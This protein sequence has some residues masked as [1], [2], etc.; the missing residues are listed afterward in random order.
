MSQIN[1]NQEPNQYDASETKS[2]GDVTNIYVEGNYNKKING[3]YIHGNSTITQ[4]SN[5]KS[6][7]IEFFNEHKSKFLKG[8]L[9]SLK[10]TLGGISTSLIISYILLPPLSNYFV[11]VG[12]DKEE[13]KEKLF[14]LELALKIDKNNDKA[15]AEIGYIYENNK[16][17][18]DAEKYYRDASSKGNIA[19]CNNRA[20][21]VLTKRSYFPSEKLSEV[22]NMLKSICWNRLNKIDRS[23]QEEEDDNTYY[24][25][26]KNLGWVQ[27]LQHNYISAEANLKHAMKLQKEKADAH[28]LLAKIWEAKGNKTEMVKA[29]E[30][31]IAYATDQEDDPTW[32]LESRQRIIDAE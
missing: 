26:L 17:Y 24:A 23:G 2:S 6:K 28:C 5:I 19:A 22:E 9:T 25:I 7:L 10:I 13:E 11:Q 1:S 16:E 12:F 21:L 8:I 32:I 15:L 29:S 30:F 14:F 31:C 27:L 3:N 18:N 20:R 4:S